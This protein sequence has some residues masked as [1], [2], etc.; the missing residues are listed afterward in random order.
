MAKLNAMRAGLLPACAAALLAGCGALSHTNIPLDDVGQTGAPPL[1]GQRPGGQ[2]VRATFK[3]DGDRGNPRVL[4][5]LA[6]SGGGS[7]AAYLSASTMLKLQ[8]LYEDVD[9]LREVDVISSVSGG[10]LPG[11]YY[12]ITRD[13]KL[14]LARRFAPLREPAAAGQVSPKLA[15]DAAAGELRC[16][17]PL[18]ADELGRLRSMPGLAAG[19]A[20]RVAELCDQSALTKLRRWDDATVRE[21]MTRNYLLRWFGNWFWPTNIIQYW[22]TAYDRSDIMAKTFEDNLFDAQPLNRPLR[23]GDLNPARPYLIVNATNATEQNFSDPLLLDPYAFGSVFTFTD[24]D[25]QARLRSDIQDY[26]LARAVMASSA[27]PLVFHNMTL[28]NYRPQFLDRCRKPQSAEEIFCRPLYLHV[29]DGGNSDNLGLRSIKRALF[30][31]ALEGKFD[32]TVDKVV[33]LLV[34]AFTRPLG[35]L[36]TRSD[37]RGLL[38]LIV[39]FN[40]VD[41][42]DSLLQANRAKIIGEFK[43]AELRWREGDCE[44]QSQ[45]LPPALCRALDRKFGAGGKLDLRSS[46][47]FYHFGFDDVPDMALKE[48]LDQISTS[49]QIG[50]ADAADLDRAVNLVLTP[51]NQCLRQ[52]RAIVLG[53]TEDAAR[54][55]AE[56]DRIDKLPPATR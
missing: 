15:V 32:G 16:A 23:F 47:M 54:A 56:C 3:V 12:A 13:E 30:E 19:A 36:R 34:D 9:L 10:S 2:P 29:F 51:Q 26:E 33:V 24:D 55:R 7:R 39:D 31:L 21:L 35:A 6:L 18:T 40:V 52:I 44:L 22:L 4:F 50:E 20:A 25:F 17:Q 38:S 5:F 11:A 49:F 37:P 14:P 41:A 1:P 48:R 53:E 28:G 45:N 8:T 43:S 46:L 42:I 27:F